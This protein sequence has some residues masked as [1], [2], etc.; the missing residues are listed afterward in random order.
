MLSHSPMMNGGIIDTLLTYLTHFFCLSVPLIPCAW[1]IF[2]IHCRYCH[3]QFSCMQSACS[4]IGHSI[5]RVAFLAF[6]KYEQV[7]KEE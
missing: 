6:L 1:F 3:A 7:P 5:P 2:L 4:N